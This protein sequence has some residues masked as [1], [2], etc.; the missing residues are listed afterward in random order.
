MLV[1]ML[2]KMLKEPETT[3]MVC[4]QCNTPMVFGDNIYEDMNDHW[5]CPNS[6]CPLSDLYAGA[7]L[8]TASAKEVR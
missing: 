2:V 8:G 5:F 3:T 1:Q 4:K 7:D 6:E